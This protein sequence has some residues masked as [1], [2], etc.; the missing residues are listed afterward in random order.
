[1]AL[2]SITGGLL[3]LVVLLFSLGLWSASIGA[4]FISGKRVYG[5]P[6]NRQASDFLSRGAAA[7]TAVTVWSTCM[8]IFAAITVALFSLIPG[9]DI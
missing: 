4:A 7:A 8:G 5:I 9:S 1:M 6:K 3:F 2:L